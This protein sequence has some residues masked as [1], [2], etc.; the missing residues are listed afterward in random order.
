MNYRPKSTDELK[1]MD[2]LPAGTYPFRVTTAEDAVSNAGNEM[3]KLK[4][5]VMDPATSRQTFVFD[6]L[7][8]AMAHKLR[9]FCEAVDILDKYES[10][11][12][13]PKDCEGLEGEL[14]LIVEPAKG[15]W[16]AKN[17]VR[18]YNIFAED[19]KPAESTALNAKAVESE[20][21]SI[22]F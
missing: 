17:A 11:T 9:H 16:Q 7:L 20:D 2:L 5:H 8:E 1:A 3:I 6:Y 4:L 19:A 14:E 12:L 18:D 21:D 10:G 13:T 15:D 22:P